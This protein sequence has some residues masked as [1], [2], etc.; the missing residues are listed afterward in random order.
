[1]ALIKKCPYCQANQ[2]FWGLVKQR[3]L[4]KDGGVLT[5]TSCGSVISSSEGAQIPLLAGGGGLCGFIVGKIAGNYIY[6]NELP[7]LIGALVA[8][9]FFLFGTYLTAPIRDA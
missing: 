8:F 5:C 6:G 2:A 3:L 9:V 4:A 7:I 1:M